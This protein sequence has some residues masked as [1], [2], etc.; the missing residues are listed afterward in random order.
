MG[1]DLREKLKRMTRK[2]LL[3]F[4]D[5]NRIDYYGEWL[6]FPTFEAG[7]GGYW[8]AAAVWV[9]TLHNHAKIILE[10]SPNSSFFPLSRP[11]VLVN[12]MTSTKS[13]KIVLE[14]D[15]R[16]SSFTPTSKE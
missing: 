5:Q 7:S 16:L 4:L 1:I 2:T 3:P 11:P 6:F 14:N 15:V 13:L 9:I 12:S 10:F 8:E